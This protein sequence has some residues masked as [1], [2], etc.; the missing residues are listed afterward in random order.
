[1]YSV[2]GLAT[3]RRIMKLVSVKLPETLIEDLE[4]LVGMGLY[5]SRS[6]AMRVAIRDL[7]RNELWKVEVSS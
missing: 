3:G 1:M 4:K 2:S 7:L 6:A 5:Q